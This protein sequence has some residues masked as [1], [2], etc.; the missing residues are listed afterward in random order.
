MITVNV[1][2]TSELIRDLRKAKADVRKDAYKVIK[3]QAE[4]IKYDAQG[5]VPIGAT[6][7]LLASIKSSSSKKTLT[8]S[9]SAGGQVGGNDAYYAVFV[10]FGTHKMAAQP[11]LY[12][13]G[14]A[15]EQET[16]ERLTA[17]L[18]EALRKGVEG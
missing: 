15:H 11:F 3:E 5:R 12:P 4:K 18:Y 9:V 17:V 13:S 2:N 14:R 7:A 16:E 6:M 10:E 1:K 8:G